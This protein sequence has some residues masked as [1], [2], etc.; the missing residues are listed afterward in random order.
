MVVLYLQYVVAILTLAVGAGAY[1]IARR[2]EH[3]T[4]DQRA[5]WRLAAAAF[6]LSGANGLASST[7]ALWGMLSGDGTFAMDFAVRAKMVG[8]DG[9]GLMMVGYAVGMI[10]RL[11]TG[12][13]ARTGSLGR[14]TARLLPWMLAGS[15]LGLFDETDGGHYSLVAA[16]SALAVV[17]LL[18]A[19]WLSVARGA[20]DYLLW[21]AILAYTVREA[22]DVSLISVFSWIG[23][24]GAWLPSFRTLQEVAVATYLLMLACV[25]RR[26][27]LARRGRPVPTLFELDGWAPAASAHRRGGG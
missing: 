8:N 2:A 5:L 26:L 17:L 12:R 10:L 9:R 13:L 27:V 24:P 4:V 25:A 22:I 18:A 11:A 7:T 1:L 14:E 21:L 20:M 19:L 23:V 3:G 6:L 16:I 15:L